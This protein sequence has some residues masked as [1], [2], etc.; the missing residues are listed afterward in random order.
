M[1][2]SK[3]TVV[4]NTG[5]KFGAADH[6]LHVRVDRDG[7]EVDLMLTEHAFQL[8]ARTAEKNPEDVPASPGLLGKLLG[9]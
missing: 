4:Q 3:V 7:Q 9:W 6:Y 5:K 8:A 1:S 2:V